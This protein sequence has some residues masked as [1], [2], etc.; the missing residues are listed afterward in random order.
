M[1][2][3]SWS[4]NNF[5]KNLKSLIDIIELV[6]KFNIDLVGK[7]LAIDLTKKLKCVQYYKQCVKISTKSESEIKYHAKIFS[8]I[9]GEI[10]LEDSEWLSKGKLI[11]KYG[12]D[13]QII[14]P[15]S[16][17]YNLSLTTKNYCSELK[18]KNNVHKKLINSPDLIKLLTLKLF[19]SSN[20]N[21][22][23]YLLDELNKHIAKI[24][25]PATKSNPQNV[26]QMINNPDGMNIGK[27]VSSLFSSFQSSLDDEDKSEV[28][29]ENDINNVVQNIFSNDETKS[30]IT[31]L[32]CGIQNA[33]DPMEAINSLSETVSRPEFIEAVKKTT[34]NTSNQLIKDK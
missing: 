9:L 6:Y 22:D 31:N 30:M 10:D 5:A 34:T 12:K 15:I 26:L 27:M 29:S 7:N 1:E 2:A 19:V 20:P 24:E 4:Y 21:L 13:T 18:T 3:K 23:E 11:A 8:N 28:P 17:C 16:D 32:I 14:L 25:K 33:G